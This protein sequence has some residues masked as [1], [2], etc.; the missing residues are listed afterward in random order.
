MKKE[1]IPNNIKELI[2]IFAD[3]VGNELEKKHN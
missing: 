3:I 2:S 1:Q